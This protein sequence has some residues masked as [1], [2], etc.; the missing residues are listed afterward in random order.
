MRWLPSVPWWGWHPC[1][2]R[3]LWGNFTW[4]IWAKNGRE[5]VTGDF[6]KSRNQTRAP[7]VVQWLRIH[8]PVP[9]TQIRSLVW[10]D[11]TCSERRASVPWR[12]SP[13][14]SPPAV[15]TRAQSPRACA[16]RQEKHEW[17]LQLES[18]PPLASTGESL[19]AAMK[20]QCSRKLNKNPSQTKKGIPLV[21]LPAFRFYPASSCY[22]YCC[23]SN[24]WMNPTDR[25]SSVVTY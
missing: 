7:L 22:L 8:L 25:E 2:W 24:A 23:L 16:Q 4:I 3:Q 19:H 10:Q 20:T 5:D 13:H 6:E 17:A 21:G 18:K 12:L 14:A 11:P 9:G 15:T 1:L